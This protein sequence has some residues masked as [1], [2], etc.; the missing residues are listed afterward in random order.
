MRQ[1]LNK[2]AVINLANQGKRPNEIASLLNYNHK[3]VRMVLWKEGFTFPT[4]GIIN[5]GGVVEDRKDEI[6]QL[7]QDGLKPK[8]IAERLNLNPVTVSSFFY[9]R[10]IRFNPIINNPSYFNVIDSK[11]KAYFLGF[12]A[13][14]G[15]LVKQRNTTVLTITIKIE[16]R[17]VL[18]TLKSEL[19][20]E[21]N[22]LEIKRKCSFNPLK[23]IHHIRL[24]FANNEINHA[25][26]KYGITERKSLTMPSLINNIPEQFRDAF[27]I[28]YLDGDGSITK[29]NSVYS[30]RLKKTIP[31]STAKTR[32]VS[33]KGT[34]EFLQGIAD[35][36]GFEIY[37]LKQNKGQK[38]HTLTIS[39]SKEVIKI[40][41]C[42]VNSDFFL[43]RKYLK[44]IS[45]PLYQVQTI[46]SS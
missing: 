19:Q 9:R 21:H 43:Q 31:T 1:K 16:D 14:D 44:L 45:N 39:N 3:S 37:S 18:D 38:I 20:A 2:E 27:I 17:I 15:A 6:F 35:H 5:L 32:I 30:K 12:I 10:K 8:Q 28:G 26:R 34:F 46:S 33:F 36:L 13:A 40:A 7:Y 23:E 29:P 25:L 41:R 11:N 42:Y 24:S 22:L 4:K